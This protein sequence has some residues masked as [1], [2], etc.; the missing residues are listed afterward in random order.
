VLRHTLFVAAAFVVGAG[1]ASA[2]TL[3][4]RLVRDMVAQHADVLSAME[5]AV[6]SS[7]GCATVASTDPKDVGEKCDADEKG[8]IRTGEPDVEAPTKEDPVYDITQALHDASGN[9]IGAVGMDIKPSAGKDRAAIV[10]VARDLLRELEAQIPSR[11]KLVERST[12]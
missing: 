5:V 8:P 9:L 7:K 10:A 6:Q 2:Q 11:G 1:P 3:A 4:Q 12:R